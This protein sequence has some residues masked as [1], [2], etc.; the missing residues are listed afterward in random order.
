[1]EAGGV[2]A[3]LA[4]GSAVEFGPRPPADAYGEPPADWHR[5]FYS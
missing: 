5:R 4:H 3:E 2:I 1:V